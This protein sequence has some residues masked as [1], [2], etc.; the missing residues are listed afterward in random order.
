MSAEKAVKALERA[1]HVLGF[2]DAGELEA[3]LPR[4]AQADL[5]ILALRQST[6]ELCSAERAR[7][8]DAR[9]KNLIKEP[10]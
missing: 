9:V 6:R 10:A 7:R 1:V 4:V 3:L 5:Q 8:E 2:V